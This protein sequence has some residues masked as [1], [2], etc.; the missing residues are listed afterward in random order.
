MKYINYMVQKLLHMLKIL[1]TS[2]SE[3]TSA[4]QQNLALCKLT[5]FTGVQVQEIR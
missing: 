3:I 5:S 4:F 2:P 1:G